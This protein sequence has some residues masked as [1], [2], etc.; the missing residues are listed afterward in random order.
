MCHKRGC[1]ASECADR[2]K[3]E[4]LRGEPEMISR[5]EVDSRALWRPDASVSFKTCTRAMDDNEALP[6]IGRTIPNDNSSTVIIPKLNFRFPGC[7]VTIR[8][9]RADRRREEHC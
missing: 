2:R 8:E 7:A 9:T 5:H 3:F 1:C 6:M 4:I